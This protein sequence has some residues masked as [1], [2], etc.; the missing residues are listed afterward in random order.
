MQVYSFL[1]SIEAPL[2]PSPEATEDTVTT[3]KRRLNHSTTPAVPATAYP[4]LIY[5]Y[6]LPACHRDLP[7]PGYLFHSL[8]LQL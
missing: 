6:V 5:A 4:P 7:R 8:P 2:P 3:L 1:S